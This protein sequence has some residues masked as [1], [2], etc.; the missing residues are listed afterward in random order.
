MALHSHGAQQFD[1]E[2]S[3]RSQLGLVAH[4]PNLSILEAEAG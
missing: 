2:K 1:P 4:V 3:Q